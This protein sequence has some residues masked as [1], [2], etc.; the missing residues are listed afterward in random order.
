V[1]E[2]AKALSAVQIWV[3]VVLIDMQLIILLSSF[4][5]QVS[6]AGLEADSIVYILSAKFLMDQVKT[7][8]SGWLKYNR[9]RYRKTNCRNLHRFAA[10]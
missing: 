1:F 8:I 6:T 5:I 2:L 7:F 4:I 10:L 3:Q 9:F